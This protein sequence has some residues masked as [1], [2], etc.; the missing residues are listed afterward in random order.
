ST[1]FGP[2]PRLRPRPLAEAAPPRF[3]DRGGQPGQSR[4]PGDPLLFEADV[5][6]GPDASGGAGLRT[7]RFPE[8]AATGFRLAHPTVLWTAPGGFD[9]DHGLDIG[10]VGAQAVEEREPV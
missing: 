7:G 1:P 6:L 2:V 5:P 10:Q 3:P 4:V 9:Q 8:R